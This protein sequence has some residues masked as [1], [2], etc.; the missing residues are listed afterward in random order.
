MSP[1]EGAF[2]MEVIIES[3]EPEIRLPILP[4]QLTMVLMIIVSKHTSKAFTYGL[5]LRGCIRLQPD[6]LDRY[7]PQNLRADS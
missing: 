3:L 7:W 1:A 6:Y 2:G 5:F 4:F